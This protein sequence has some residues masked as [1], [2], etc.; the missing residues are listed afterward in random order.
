VAGVGVTWGVHGRQQLREA[1]AARL[2]ESF[3]ELHPC[4]EQ[5]DCVTR[6]NM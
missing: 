1:G 4:L 2:L 3:D 6:P 5:P